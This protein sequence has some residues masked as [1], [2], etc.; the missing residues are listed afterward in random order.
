MVIDETHD[1]SRR[2]WVESAEKS[3]T[4]FPIQ[5]LPLCV[6]RREGQGPQGGIGIGDQILDLK[7]AFERGL[8]SGAASQAAEAAC[9]ETLNALMAMGPKFSSALRASVSE[10]LSTGPAGERAKADRRHILFPMAEARLEL[11]AFIRSYTDFTCSIDHTRRR[12]GRVPEVLMRL[13]VAY[14]GRASS[15]RLDRTPVVRPSGQFKAD[16]ETVAYGPEPRLDFELEFAAFVGMPSEFGEPV[17]VAESADHIFGFVLLNDWSARG[18]QHYEMMLGPF[19]GKS[20]VTTISPW[21]VTQEALA[22]F[23]VPAVARG[24]SLIAVPEHLRDEN[25]QRDGGLNLELTADFQTQRMRRDGLAPERIVTTNFAEMIW[26]FAQMLAHHTSNGC[27]LEAGDLLA[28]GTVS[29]SDPDARACMGEINEH[30]KA[31]LRLPN[32][33]TRMWIEDGDEVTFRARASRAGFVPIG[34]GTCAGRVEAA[35]TQ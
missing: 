20:F 28:S 16:D 33:E 3:G 8:F 13:P 9:G 23:R 24:S 29:G 14:H 25:D 30:G 18:I 35:R 17:P 12:Q 22:P 19:L 7:A 10:L 26:T 6:F 27:N 32:G 31:S 15:I 1:A 4:D 2:S 11:P 34:F 5:N 21:I